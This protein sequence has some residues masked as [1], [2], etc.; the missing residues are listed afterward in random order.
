MEQVLHQLSEEDVPSSSVTKK[1][2]TEV[3]PHM[4]FLHYEK[5]GGTSAPHIDLC[6][7]HRVNLSI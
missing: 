1:I 5:V 2:I 6:R 4:R 3:L 7:Y